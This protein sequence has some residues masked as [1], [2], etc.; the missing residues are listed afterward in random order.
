[1]F[2][3]IAQHLSLPQPLI[4]K[5]AGT[6]KRRR[7][8]R[9]CP[10][11]AQVEHLESRQLLAATAISDDFKV[12][13]PA[14][15]SPDRYPYDAAMMED[16]RFVMVWTDLPPYVP[17]YVN[18]NLYAQ[19]FHADGSKLGEMMTIAATSQ[20]SESQASVAIAPNG[21]FV[22][23]WLSQRVIRDVDPDRDIEFALYDWQGQRIAGG[24]VGLP[25]SAGFRMQESPPD[26]DMADDGSFVI[27]AQAD[28]KVAQSELSAMYY[29][30]YDSLGRALT[31][32]I[33]YFNVD[34][35]S[36]GEKRNPQI[37]VRPDGKGFVL[38]YDRTVRIWIEGDPDIVISET[39][40][41]QI[42]TYNLDSDTG[43]ASRRTTYTVDG[44]QESWSPD[45][46]ID[47]RNRFT[48]G[49][50]RHTGIGFYTVQM[51]HF[52]WNGRLL[53]QDLEVSRLRKSLASQTTRDRG[54]STAPKSICRRRRVVRHHLVRHLRHVIRDEHRSRRIRQRVRR[55]R[56]PTD[57]QCTQRADMGT[58]EPAIQNRLSISSSGYQV[59]R[60]IRHC[61]RGPR[62]CL[63]KNLPEPDPNGAASGLEWKCRQSNRESG[64][65]IDE[66]CRG[67]C[68]RRGGYR[69]RFCVM[70]F[71][72]PC[73]VPGYTIRF[74]ER[75]GDV[76]QLGRIG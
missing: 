71:Q 36:G 57:H 19:R 30:A 40:H 68:H 44:S 58:R 5:S 16:G 38:A 51:Q 55:L 27:V 6:K 43:I 41:V 56:S 23:T 24:R 28:L 59:G 2:K 15:D 62:R 39:K 11:T 4:T 61:F 75:G 73:L 69:C 64:S 54:G 42:S 22:V 45:I 35:P 8:A 34:D 67:A 26:V 66:Q 72:Q 70:A 14:A 60:W 13:R 32:N 74:Q 7:A 17:G 12:E 48:V 52:D 53:K 1:M 21:N 65:G 50:V 63:C 31:E 46:A 10:A 9:P 76:S 29:R 37:A 47:P 3:A 20:F 49:F 18:F 25:D 33:Q